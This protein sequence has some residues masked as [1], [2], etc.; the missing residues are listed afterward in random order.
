MMVG[1]DCKRILLLRRLT[2]TE[3]TR[4]RSS[5]LPVSFSTIEASVTSCSCVL[6][7]RS[8]MRCSQISCT[9]WR[10]ACCMRWMICARHAAG[11]FVGFRQQ[12]ALVRDFL[13]LA[14]ERVVLQKLGDDLLGG[15]PLG[16]R[17]RV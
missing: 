1:S 16:D 3:A 7:G 2:N 12:R 4:E 9:K 14:G 13:D 10:C 5:G 11:E 17:Q 15:Q 8:A 6:T